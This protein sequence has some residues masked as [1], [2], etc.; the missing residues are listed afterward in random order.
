MLPS[1]LGVVHW[2]AHVPFWIKFMLYILLHFLYFHFISLST[3][4]KFYLSILVSA[5]NTC[6][7]KTC[8]KGYWLD[9]LTLFPIFAVRKLMIRTQLNV[10]RFL[11]LMCF[12]VYNGFCLF[13]GLVFSKCLVLNI[14]FSQF[15]LPVLPHCS[16]GPWWLSCFSFGLVG[17]VWMRVSWQ[18]F[19][20]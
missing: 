19:C 13:I 1:S 8:K 7:N 9:Y 16:V 15:D 14:V 10:L 6:K 12:N 11:R 18:K 17:S 4:A 2:W 3:F 5:E 20:F